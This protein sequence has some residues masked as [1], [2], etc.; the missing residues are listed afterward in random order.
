M[1]IVFNSHISRVKSLPEKYNL[2][3][4]LISVKKKK[5]TLIDIF[6]KMEFPHYFTY[7]ENFIV[8]ERLSS[9]SV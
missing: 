9:M 5:N 4:F 6:V 1:N 7:K 3:I 2:K 8:Q